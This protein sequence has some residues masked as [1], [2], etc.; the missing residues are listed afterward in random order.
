[1]SERDYR[2]LYTFLDYCHDNKIDNKLVKQICSKIMEEHEKVGYKFSMRCQ[3][4]YVKMMMK[5]FQ[6][7]ANKLD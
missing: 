6:Y 5:V 7:D 2:Q 1:M 3:I 4:A